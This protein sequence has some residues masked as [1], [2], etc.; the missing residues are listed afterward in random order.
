MHAAPYCMQYGT[1]TA[2]TLWARQGD[3][4]PAP[5]T[6]S[7]LLVSGSQDHIRT[8]PR[9]LPSIIELPWAVRIPRAENLCAAVAEQEHPPLSHVAVISTLLYDL[10]H[11]R[12]KLLWKKT[13]RHK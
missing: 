3:A 12:S 1:R 6:P 10:M 4:T 2:N 11:H 5:T 7:H 9:Q 13:I 8:R